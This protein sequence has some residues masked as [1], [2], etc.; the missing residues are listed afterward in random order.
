MRV[1][2]PVSVGADDA[3]L[4][5]A[6]DGGGEVS[7]D[8]SVVVAERDAF[9]LGDEHP[10]S[11]GLLNENPGGTLTLAALASLF[12][13]SLEGANSPFVAGP[14]GLDP[15]SNPDFLLSELLVEKGVLTRLAGEEF[16]PSLEKGGVVASP[17]E[18]TAAVRV[19]RSG[20]RASPGT[21]GR[22]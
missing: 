9:R 18:E 22:G 2:L 15:L 10:R 20:W 5:A 17:V 11:I 19:R 1:V 3:D 14:S 6:K 12:S 16:V 8:G 7:D 13:Q 4:V 21:I